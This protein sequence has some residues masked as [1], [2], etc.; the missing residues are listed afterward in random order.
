MHF[1]QFLS[2]ALYY[3]ADMHVFSKSAQRTLTW[4]AVSATQRCAHLCHHWFHSALCCTAHYQQEF[5]KVQFLVNAF[6]VCRRFYR[7]HFSHD[8]HAHGVNNKKLWQQNV[9]FRFI[10]SCWI[11]AGIFAQLVLETA[12]ELVLPS[13]HVKRN[14]LQSLTRRKKQNKRGKKKKQK[15]KKHNKFVG[16]NRP[17]KYGQVIALA[18][19]QK[20]VHN[21]LLNLLKQ[22]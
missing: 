11:F 6:S 17:H 21:L 1:W 5:S 14:C 8:F 9:Y 16:T 15:A 2:A 3:H 4:Q 7:S 20:C 18:I 10:H 12:E 19:A 22:Q 13:V